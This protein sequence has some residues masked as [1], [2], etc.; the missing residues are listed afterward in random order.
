MKKEVKLY[1]LYGAFFLLAISSILIYE[2]YQTK[3]TRNLIVAEAQRLGG[4]ITAAQGK[5]QTLESNVGKV[6]KE[7]NDINSELDRKESAIQSLTGELQ[8]VKIESQQQVSELQDKISKLKAQ[9]QDFSDVIEK[10]IPSVVSIRTDV[11][12]GSGFIIEENGY[13]V[14]NYHV[15]ENARAGTAITSDN[16]RHSIR[17]VGF[18]EKADIAV[19]DLD[20]GNFKKLSW[21]SSQRTQI[22]ES[23]IAVG[24]PGGLDFTV[25]KG[26]VSAFRKDAEGNDL[27]QID[28]PINPGNSGGPLI[29]S[30]GRVI[31]VN[32]KKIEGFEGVGF[33]LASDYVEDIVQD[34]I[35]ADR[36]R[37]Q[38]G[39]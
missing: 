17:I 33:A 2:N 27:I 28:V 23:V 18:N 12:A 29:N 20:D 37:Q 6:E 19:L 8:E 5:I 25:T 30:E 26:I 38:Q 39:S 16:E 21:G 7:I 22:G 9:N 1:L 14:T 15:I 10:A 3:Q 11:G 4:L 36:A 34:L 35:D 13:T 31:G 32:T 24:N